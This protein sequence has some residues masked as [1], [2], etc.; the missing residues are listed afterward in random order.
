MQTK[1]R[2]R[3]KETH[4]RLNLRPY[5]VSRDDEAEDIRTDWDLQVRLQL[6]TGGVPAD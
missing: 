5:F 4:R 6:A 1:L 2:S 3:R